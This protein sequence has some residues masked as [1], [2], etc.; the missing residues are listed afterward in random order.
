M[1][2]FKSFGKGNA[3]VFFA[4][5]I[6]SFLLFGCASSS[7][8]RMEKGLS[9]EVFEH[10]GS[11][12]RQPATIGVLIPNELK[13]ATIV[14]QVG[15]TKYNLD[16]GNTL[17][18]KIIQILSYKFDRVVLLVDERTE[19]AIPWDLKM[20][21][22]LAEADLSLT[23]KSGFST[24]TMKSG[25]YID[26]KATVVNRQGQVVWFGSAREEGF[27]EAAAGEGQ[28]ADIQGGLSEAIDIAVAKIAAQMT[29]SEALRGAIHESIRK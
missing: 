3:K 4:L 9:L 18:A 29:R 1:I 27:G 17:G 16:L 21:V 22:E 11:I 5:T 19:P 8:I 10:L 14:R 12:D 6:L 7:N 24:Y 28:V 23:R 26:L 15:E 25:G 20:S 2:I 13:S